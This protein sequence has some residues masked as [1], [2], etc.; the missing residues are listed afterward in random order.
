MRGLLRRIALFVTLLWLLWH[1]EILNRIPSNIRKL[2][3]DI[4]MTLICGLILCW[5]L[6][7]EPE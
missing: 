5:V 2:E 7:T 3:T 1:T 6:W 4:V